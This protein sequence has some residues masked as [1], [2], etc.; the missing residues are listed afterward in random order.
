[1]EGR[2]GSGNDEHDINHFTEGIN[3]RW[4]KMQ[5]EMCVNSFGSVFVSLVQKAA[6]DFI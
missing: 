5:K 6:N 4:A 2:G 1:M 3:Q